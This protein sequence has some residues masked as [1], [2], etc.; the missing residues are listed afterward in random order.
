MSNF[1]F[2]P[3]CS[4]KGTETIS[5]G[6]G[7]QHLPQTYMQKRESTKVVTKREKTLTKVPTIGTFEKSY[8]S[9]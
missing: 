5:A 1:F 7:Q 2:I 6:S 9:P 3:A 4:L 8:A